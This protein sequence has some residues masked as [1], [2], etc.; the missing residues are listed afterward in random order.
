MDSLT[1]NVEAKQ[2][3]TQKIVASSVGCECR[4]MTNFPFD[5][6]SLPLPSKYRKGKERFVIL[7]KQDPGRVRRRSQAE[8][9]GKIPQHHVTITNHPFSSL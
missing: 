2:L 5:A 7:A 9:G 1:L 8:A 3:H 6:R 4:K